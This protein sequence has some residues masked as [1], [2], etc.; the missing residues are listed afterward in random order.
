MRYSSYT[1]PG[2]RTAQWWLC[3]GAQLHDD[4]DVG[5]D[6]AD[7]SDRRRVLRRVI[8]LVQIDGQ[9]HRRRRG[10]EQYES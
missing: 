5:L 10:G 6:I 8:P 2:A 1:V 4:Y 9:R 3:I 7:W